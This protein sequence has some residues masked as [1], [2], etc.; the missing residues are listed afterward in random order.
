MTDSRLRE[1]ERRFVASGSPEDEAAWLRARMQA[2]E[3]SED[4]QELLAYLGCC[5]PAPRA[6]QAP[7]SR[8]PHEL[9]GWVH[10]LPH[11]E[12][13]RHYPWSIEI[14]WRV[15]VALARAIPDREVTAALTAARLMEQWVAEPADALARELVALQDSLDSQIPRWAILPRARRQRRLCG[16]LACAMMPARWPGIS[17]NA[18]PSK[19][20]E[21]LAEELGV[22][23]VRKAL[24]AEIVPW[25]LGYTDPVRVRVAAR[26]REA[27]NG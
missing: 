3:L 26:Q 6:Y 15:G 19:A 4:W 10:G 20:T 21:F 8:T 14:F 7:P 24:L 23:L 17:V 13:A 1:L 16:G 2:G 25:A 27:A 9:G 11:F 22:P 12:G 5:V 18:M